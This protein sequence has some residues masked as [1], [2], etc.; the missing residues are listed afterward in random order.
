MLIPD[1][2]KYRHNVA[3]LGLGRPEIVNCSTPLEVQPR[4]RKAVDASVPCREIPLDSS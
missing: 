3:C 1:C 4:S 2:V